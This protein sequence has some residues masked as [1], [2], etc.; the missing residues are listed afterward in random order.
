MFVSPRAVGWLEKEAEKNGTKGAQKEKE[1]HCRLLTWTGSS[2]AHVHA[3]VYQGSV[4]PMS[5][6][7]C[8]PVTYR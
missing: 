5:N 6:R 8:R 1:E 2:T 7:V 3:D 4:L